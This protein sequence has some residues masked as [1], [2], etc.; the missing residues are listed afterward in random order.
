MGA[1]YLFVFLSLIITSLKL[2][3]IKENRI[4]F[5]LFLIFFSYFIPLMYEYVR[6]PILT[7]RY[8]MFVL[9]PIFTIIS[10]FAFVNENIKF[11]KI[12]II[13]VVILTLVN[14]FIE[15]VYRENTKP[16]YNK[17]LNKILTNNNLNVS[18]YSDQKT[19]PVLKNYIINLE[20]FK[21]NNFYFNEINH[22]VNNKKD[23]WL[24]CYE[25]VVGFNC[26]IN[27]NE[28]IDYNVVE[29][30]TFHLINAKKIT[31]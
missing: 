5:L 14:L 17:I 13:T 26:K 23:F 24:I 10:Y 21:N 28:D 15:I 18:L 19:Y 16:E 12:I 22:Y 1:L 29:T 2:L 4:I 8:I 30:F 31:F 25:P 20:I 27:I 3:F 9:I 6:F 11:K 7:D